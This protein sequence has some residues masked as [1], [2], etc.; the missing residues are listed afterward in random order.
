M[1]DQGAFEKRLF[2]CVKHTGIWLSIC[3]TTVTGTVLATTEFSDFYVLVT[4]LTPPT[5]ETNTRVSQNV[6]GASCAD[7]P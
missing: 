1:N 6:L 4:K 3:R 7:P 5:S 2:L